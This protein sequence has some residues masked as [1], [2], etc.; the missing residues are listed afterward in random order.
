MDL[1]GLQSSSRPEKAG[2]KPVPGSRPMSSLKAGLIL[3]GLTLIFY[4]KIVLVHQYSMLLGFEGVNQAYAW[5]NFWVSTIRQG[6][7]PIWD[8]FTFS[9]HAFAGEMQTGAFYP[10]YL[11]FLAVP[12]HHGVFSPQLYHVFYVLTHALCAWFAYL[13]AREFRLSAFAGLL[14]GVCFSLGGT[15][16][17]FSGWP[18]LLQSGIWLPLVV[19]LLVRALKAT[20]IESVIAY[21]ALSGLSLAMAVLAGGMH[22]V[23]MEAIVVVSA[24]IFYAATSSQEHDHPRTAWTR[25]AIA[26]G[27]CIAFALAGGAVSTAAFN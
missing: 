15:L 19:L 22:L 13:L 11:V 3:L 12:F 1:T 25:A 6:I 23:I 9:G 4:W 26:V 17:R 5:F 21:S 18:H 27:V 8:P 10:P 16:V 24:G 2:E 14:S 20:Q 7:W